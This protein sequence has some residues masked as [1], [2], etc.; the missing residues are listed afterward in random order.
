MSILAHNS[1]PNSPGTSGFRPSDWPA[2]NSARSSGA[3]TQAE[4]SVSRA[5]PDL[6]RRRQLSHDIHH[7]LGTIMMLAYLISDAS[8]VGDESKDR[9]RQILGET[10]WLEQL[11][12]AYEETVLDV[13][14][15]GQ[16]TPPA[17]IRL[18]VLAGEVVAAMKLSTLTRVTFAAVETWA[19]ADRLAFWRALRNVVGNA[20]RAAG[21]SGQVD[22]RVTAEDGWALAQVDDDGPGFGAVPPGPGSLGLGIVQDMVAA[23]GGELEIRRGVLGGCCV[24]LRLLLPAATAN[25]GQTI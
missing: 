12:R 20:V 25:D 18:D 5:D 6:L 3:A 22:V 10:R 1:N 8:D 17:P 2:P 16:P 13:R 15:A 11:Q 24:R 21:G 19:H 9:A 7:E 23:W 14:G 4:P